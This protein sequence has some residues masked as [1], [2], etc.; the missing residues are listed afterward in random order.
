MKYTG[1]LIITTLLCV[2]MTPS[3]L[4]EKSKLHPTD[5]V[6]V[7]MPTQGNKVA[8]IVK[9]HQTPQGV[10]VTA[11]VTGLKPGQHGF[12]IHEY[13]DCSAPDAASA[14]GHFNPKHMQH[15]GPHDAKRH[16][17][18]L[19]NIEATTKGPASYKDVD[20]AISLKGV[21]GII[22]R[23][24]IIHA[25]EDDLKSQPAGNSGVRIACGV[26]GIAEAK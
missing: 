26:I 16:A 15:A 14:G 19:G 22:G 13:G 17:G 3:V 10:E 23:S 21:K 9:F 18:D 25:S 6:A 4:A 20:N 8:G 7:L 12:H 2:F 11:E 5:A 1:K 24:V